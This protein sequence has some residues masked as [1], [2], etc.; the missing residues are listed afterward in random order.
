VISAPIAHVGGIPIEETLASLGPALLV[1]FGV[2]WANLRARLRRVRS[3][4]TAHD[5]PRKKG[6][7]GAGCGRAGLNS[8]RDDEPLAKRG[9]P[10]RQ[11]AP[12]PDRE[13][14]A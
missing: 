7:R 2:A 11:P 6:A 9:A 5:P 12:R 13:A 3:R 14:L 4:A 10:R 8:N 1:A